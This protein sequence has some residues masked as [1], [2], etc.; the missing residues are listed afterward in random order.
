MTARGGGE[1][2]DS[3]LEVVADLSGADVVCLDLVSLFRCIFSLGRLVLIYACHGR[4]NHSCGP[5]RR[6]TTF[7]ILRFNCL[8]CLPTFAGFAS[9]I[10]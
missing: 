8:G 4:V 10:L 9:S 2:D 7:F 6:A 3:Q 1:G 5:N